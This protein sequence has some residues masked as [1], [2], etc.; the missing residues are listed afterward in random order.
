MTFREEL[1]KA[2][3]PWVAVKTTKYGSYNTDDLYEYLVDLTNSDITEFM[4]NGTG[5]F[6]NNVA[7]V[8][9]EM[10]AKKFHTKIS[11]KIY[12]LNS[13]GFQELDRTLGL[14][15]S[16]DA[17]IIVEDLKKSIRDIQTKLNQMNSILE[18]IA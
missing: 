16:H 18:Q 7:W 3:L 17:A 9:A 2:A 4:S 11:P 13:L 12:R 15:E 10:T 8:T 5:K 6:R 14:P 1:F